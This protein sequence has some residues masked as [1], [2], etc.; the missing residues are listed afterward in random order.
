MQELLVCW[1][2]RC[3][4]LGLLLLELENLFIIELKKYPEL[5]GTNKNH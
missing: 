5:E 2:F 1:Q 4:S 3:L